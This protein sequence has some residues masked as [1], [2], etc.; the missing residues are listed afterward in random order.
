MGLLDFFKKK[1]SHY[2][3]TNIRVQDLDVGFVFEYDLST[4]VVEALFEYDWGDNYFTREFQV[5]NGSVTR[6]LGLEEDDGVQLSMMEKKK[7]RAIDTNLPEHLMEKQEPPKRISYAG[8]DYYLENA[9]AGYFHDVA[10][11]DVWEEFRAW[12]FEDEDGKHLLCI[13]QW[14]EQEFEAAVGIS[15]QEYEISNILPGQSY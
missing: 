6:F 10:K 15:L 7:I 12:D 11:G 13:E 9:A 14:D 1:E 5:S 3:S 2:D 8:V 4:W